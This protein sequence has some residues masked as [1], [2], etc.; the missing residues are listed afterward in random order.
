MLDPDI[1][2]PSTLGLMH[3]DRA[4]RELS[5]CVRVDEAKSIRDKA[6]AL[7]VYAKQAKDRTL[8]RNATEI[9][10]RAE[11]R[12]GELLIE[13][14]QKRERANRGGDRRSKSRAATLVKLSTL[15]LNKTQSSRWQ[16]LARLPKA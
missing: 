10:I 7:Q 15:G 6:I 1:V 11:I 9:R 12:V 4:R 13:L 3:Y 14:A 8:E 2:A 16:A 5:E